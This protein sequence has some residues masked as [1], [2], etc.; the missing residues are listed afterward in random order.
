MSQVEVT[1]SQNCLNEETKTIQYGEQVAFA[2]IAK[3]GK[4]TYFY[5]NEPSEL[6]EQLQNFQG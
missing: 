4:L 5:G 3:D 2:F 1:T 6:I